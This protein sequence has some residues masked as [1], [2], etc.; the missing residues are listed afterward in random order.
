M[1]DPDA[2]ALTEA[3]SQETLTRTLAEAARLQEAGQPA[4]ALVLYELVLAE[5][6]ET[7]QAALAASR[8]AEAL[9]NVD[10]AIAFAD[11]AAAKLGRIWPL[12]RL[13]QTWRKE[14]RLIE[15]AETFRRAAVLAPQRPEPH[16][17]L[18]GCARD[19]G[20]YAKAAEAQAWAVSLDPSDNAAQL[21]LARDMRRLGQVTDASALVARI[22]EAEPGYVAAAK[23]AASLAAATPGATP[24][25]KPPAKTAAADT[26]AKLR[27][28]D[29]LRREARLAEAETAYRAVL[30]E[31]PGQLGATLGLGRCQLSGGDIAGA[32]AN[33]MA[34]ARLSRKIGP[35]MHFTA[36]CRKAG[37]LETARVCCDE[38]RELAPGAVEPL[39]EMAACARVAGE[40]TVAAQWQARAAAMVP[41]E[42]VVALSLARDQQKAGDISA[43]R[44]TLAEILARHAAH[45]GAL[46]LSAQLAQAAAAAAAPA[47]DDDPAEEEDD[48]APIRLLLQVATDCRRDGDFALAEAQYRR[49]AALAP[50][51]P[52]PWLGL[53][54]CASAQGDAATAERMADE[55][56]ALTPKPAK[57]RAGK[58]GKRHRAPS[59]TRLMTEALSLRDQ[60]D[61]GAAI[62][63]LNQV[64]VRKPTHIGA[65]LA[66][67]QLQRERGA[68]RDAVETLARAHVATP[69]DPAVTLAYARALHEAGEA[70]KGDA[71]LEAALA[72]GKVGHALLIY[73]TE[74]ALAAGKLSEARTQAEALIATQPGQAAGYNLASVALARAGAVTEALAVL[75][76]ADTACGTLPGLVVRRAQLL[77][78][79]GRLEAALSLCEGA[80]P[81]FPSHLPLWEATWHARLAVRG[82]PAAEAAAVAMAETSSDP[83]R[84]ALAALR[85]DWAMEACD[86]AAALPL[87]EQAAALAPA[88]SAYVNNLARVH[89]ARGALTETGTWLARMTRVRGSLARRQQRSG[90]TQQG[91]LETVY[92]DFRVDQAAVAAV[93]ALPTTPAARVEDLLGLCRK[94]PDNTLLAASLLEALWQAGRLGAPCGSGSGTAGI[95]QR[96]VQYWP[97]PPPDL[98]AVMTSWDVS[99]LEAMRFDDGSARRFLGTESG[100]D[101]LFAY[102]RGVTA[103]VRADLF[104]LAALAEIGGV[105]VDAFSAR[106]GP[107]APLLEPGVDLVLVRGE[108][109]LLTT[110]FLA[111]TPGHDLLRRARD[112]AALSINRGDRDL[113]WLATGPG[114]LTR[115]FAQYL[116]EA[117]EALPARLAA[118]RVWPRQALNAVVTPSCLSEWRATFQPRAAATTRRA[119]IIAPK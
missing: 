13:G 9:G 79:L 94:Y 46:K 85:G 31:V 67:G 18:A 62:A 12:L 27:M 3:T 97:A 114:L 21:D 78:Q 118:I 75:D 63:V 119:Y 80:L 59:T 15:A 103:S 44:A 11:T 113:L 19:Q 115:A 42:V 93:A 51:R 25:T 43:A 102:H 109:G 4:Q 110:G 16:L 30:A 60:G 10:R 95:P 77:R 74:R 73:A 116:A 117:P 66:L 98:A 50:G 72:Q 68:P 55:A 71:V 17:G 107:V 2:V 99:G 112:L 90:T 34:A 58:A 6:P 84:A 7:H 28:A 53:A 106:R 70:T 61:D 35:L 100:T 14:G 57:R 40:F 39:L 41:D 88:N 92:N 37:H 24:A 29:R 86:F 76:R 48:L 54:A 8:C 56:R 38:A 87:Y 105:Y 36:A 83:E 82:T 64:L 1:T 5:A 33:F 20:D 111:A 22:L 45:P 81:Q 23:L 65:L 96:L 91:F 108:L 89:L 47:G 26:L 104:R 52:E 32:K 49:A 101:V 69:D